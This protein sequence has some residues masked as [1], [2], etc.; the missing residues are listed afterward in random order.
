MKSDAENA[1]ESGADLF[2]TKP[3]SNKAFKENV[4]LLLKSIQ[5]W[6]KNEI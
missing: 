2:I 5:P 4:E 3:V 6:L 1:K